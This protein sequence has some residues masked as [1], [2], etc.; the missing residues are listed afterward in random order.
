MVT[1]FPAVTSGGVISMDIISNSA[2]ALQAK[3]TTRAIN[4]SAMPTFLLNFLA[5]TNISFY[6]IIGSLYYTCAWAVSH[7]KRASS[8][9][10]GTPSLGL[11]YGLELIADAG[12]GDDIFWIHG[13]RLNLS[14]QVIYKDTQILLFLGIFGTPGAI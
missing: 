10:P 11:G 3:G 7:D 2:G 13:V 12:H 4:R 9:F 5:I 8:A 14:P 1:V 6:D